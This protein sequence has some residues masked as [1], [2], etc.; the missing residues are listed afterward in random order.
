MQ[1]SNPHSPRHELAPVLLAV[2]V[3]ALFVVP[4]ALG[5]GAVGGLDPWAYNVLHRDTPAPDVRTEHS[6]ST[7]GPLDAW[8]VNAVRSGSALTDART[9]HSAGQNHMN[10]AAEPVAASSASTASAEMGTTFSWRDAGIGAAAAVGLMLLLGTALAIAKRRSVS[11]A[12]T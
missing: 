7:D 12:H 3:F 4:P 1:A 2:L 5:S 8:A 9:E 10:G 11:V 6:A